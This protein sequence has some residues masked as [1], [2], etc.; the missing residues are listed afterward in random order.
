MWLDSFI[1]VPTQ[2]IC[3]LHILPIPQH[4]S[5][6]HISGRKPPARSSHSAC[7][8]SGTGSHPSLMVVGGWDGSCV[9]SD[10]WLLD[11]ADGS[12]KEVLYMHMP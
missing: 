10:V 8:L 7:C 2:H 1:Y 11:V 4:W 3:A 12:W 6:L 9:F 5:K